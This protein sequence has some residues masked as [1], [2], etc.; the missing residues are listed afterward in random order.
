MADSIKGDIFYV[1][2]CVRFVDH[3]RTVL[4]GFT[5]DLVCSGTPRARATQTTASRKFCG[6]DLSVDVDYRWLC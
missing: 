5:L 1:S 2:W 4:D 6:I 3:P